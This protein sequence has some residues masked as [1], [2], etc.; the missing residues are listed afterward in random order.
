MKVPPPEVGHVCYIPTGGGTHQAL[1]CPQSSN[2]DVF[3]SVCVE[4]CTSEMEAVA[5]A[6]GMLSGFG[7]GGDGVEM[8]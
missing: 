5:D 1:L 3:I 8:G 4:E 6:W 7:G 2:I